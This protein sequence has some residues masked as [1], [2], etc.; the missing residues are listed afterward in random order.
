MKLFERVSHPTFEL[1]RRW[2]LDHFPPARDAVLVHG[3]LMMQN[4]LV[5]PDEHPLRIGVVDW[6]RTRVGHPAFD[7]AA[8]TRG[9]DKPFP[10]GEST[11]EL[12]KN[13]NNQT[14]RDIGFSEL[15]FFEI[16]GLVWRWRSEVDR[17]GGTDEF[18]DDLLQGIHQ[19]VERELP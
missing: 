5:E 18:T 9:Y 7:L 6:D 17:R 11:E 2:C 1:A 19:L 3:D 14:G 8:M 4:I 12:L 13:Y 15:R 10:T 16:L